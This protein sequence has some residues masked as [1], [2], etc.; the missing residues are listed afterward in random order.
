MS[1]SWIKMRKGIDRNA[2]VTAIAAETGLDRFS[3]VGRLHA[4]WS[5]FDDESTDGTIKIPIRDKRFANAR[6]TLA[7][8]DS[9]SGFSGFGVAMQ[10][11]G[12]LEVHDDGVFEYASLPNFDRHNS[13]TAKQRALTAAR[14]ATHALRKANAPLTVDALA[15]KRREEYTPICMSLLEVEPMGSAAKGGNGKTQQEQKP[16]C[17]IF[18]AQTS[19]AEAGYWSLGDTDRRAV[20]AALVPFAAGKP[21]ALKSP[22][23]RR[24][25]SEALENMGCPAMLAALEWAA[26][27][28]PRQRSVAAAIAH[29]KTL[30]GQAGFD[31]AKQKQEG[32][33]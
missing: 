27:Q 20:D 18:D 15:E 21:F 29:A 6:L 22:A 13:Q 14:V 24:K 9:V 8:I 23:F 4:V 7:E 10:N 16:K 26:G 31:G 2:S 1:S 32:P 28:P 17:D 11:A 12:W 3:V 19:D 30:A 5:Y 25:I 33:F